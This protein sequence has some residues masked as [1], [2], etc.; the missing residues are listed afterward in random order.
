M[1]TATHETRTLPRIDDARLEKFLHQAVADMGAAASSALTLTGYR[2]G[3]F[4]AMAN[5]GPLTAGQLAERT[6]THERYIREWLN[7]QAAGGYVSYDPSK[8][9]YELPPEQAFA[10][11]DSDSPVFLTGAFDMLATLWADTDRMA[12]AFRTGRGIG[13]HDHDSRLFSA[14]E[15]FFRGGYRAHL[16]S[17]WIPALEGVEA[18]L[19]RGAKVADVGCGHGASAIIIGQAYPKSTVLGVDYH[20]G[21]I[22]TARQRAEKAGVADRVHFERAGARDLPGTEYDLICFFDCFHDLGDPLGAARRAHQA[23]AKDGTLML[24]E[25]KAGEHVEDNLNP[26]GRLYYSASTFLCTP[27]A[28]SQDVGTA[29]G[30][31]AG[32]ARLTEILRTAGFSK[33]RRVAE[34]PFNM[35]LEARE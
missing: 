24:V 26:V 13:W 17:E 31:Q 28:L 8:Q 5:A 4:R 29:L 11:A 19:R 3:L 30:A 18:K 10:L 12:D 23:L 15:L 22:A 35:V 34:T 14:T 7:A 16:T 21:S 32:E 25:P 33:V 2:L 9:T 27:N 1:T 6:G 20:E